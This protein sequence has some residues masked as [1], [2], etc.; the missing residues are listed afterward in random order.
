MPSP[1]YSA[2]LRVRIDAALAAARHAQV[3]DHPG[4]TGAIREIVVRELLRPILPPAI[5]IGTG[6]IVD[7]TGTQ[8]AEIDIVLYDRS[9]MPPL[10]YGSGGAIGAFPVEACIYAIQIKSTS[11]ASNLSQVIKQGQSLSHLVYLREACGPHGEPINRVIP[12]YFAF[13]SD[14]SAPAAGPAEV[15]EVDRLRRRHA[16]QDFQYEDVWVGDAYRRIPFPPVRVLCVVGQGYGFYNG[17]EYVT[18]KAD[19]ATVEVIAFL[20]GVANTL[21]GFGSRR[22]TLPFG[23]YLHGPTQAEAEVKA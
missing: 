20:T 23:Y 14:L 6:K 17:N 5:D 7:H 9:L 12:V 21:I 16:P 22:L 11:S 19:A 15:P 13:K 18:C 8:S 4:L 3:I 2:D 10:L 1:L